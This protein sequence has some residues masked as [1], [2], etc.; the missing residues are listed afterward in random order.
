MKHVIR[1]SSAALLALALLLSAC[2]GP[3]LPV[4]PSMLAVTVAVDLGGEAVEGGDQLTPQGFPY[5]PDDGSIAGSVEVHVYDKDGDAVSFDVSGGTYTA[6]PSGAVGFITLTPGSESATV[7][8]PSSGN[9]YRFESFGRADGD[10]VAYDERSQD[11]AVVPSV[12]VTLRSVLEEAILVPRYPTAVATPGQVLDL[13]LV[14]MANGH[15]DFPTDYLQVPVGDFTATYGTVTNAAAGPSSVRGIRLTV[16]PA[17]TGDVTVDGHVTGLLFDGTAYATGDLPFHGGAGFSLSC[18]AAVGGEVAVDL[19]PPTVTLDSFD[20]ATRVVTGTASDAF[21]IASVEIY[22]GPVLMASTDPAKVSGTVSLIVFAPG[23]DEFTTTLAVDPVGGISA[24]ALDPSGN[25]ASTE[26]TFDDGF[27]YVDASA[28][29]G[30]D[31]SAAAPFDTIQEGIDAV[32]SGGTVFVRNGDYDGDHLVIDKPLTLRGESEAGVSVRLSTTGYGVEVSA[33]DVTIENLTIEGTDP[34]LSLSA[35]YGVKVSPQPVDDDPSTTDPVLTNFAMTDVTVKGFGR[36][37]VDL[38]G[39]DGA[40]LTR[41][42]ADGQGTAGV[43]IAI[44]GSRNVALLGVS[45]LGNDWG[46]VGLYSTPFGGINGVSGIHVDT[47][48]TFAEPVE[49]YSD[50]GAGPAGAAVE[51]L[52]LQGFTHVVKNPDFRADGDAFTFYMRTESGAVALANGLAT[53]ERSYV[54][55]L[56]ADVNGFVVAQNRFV[57]GVGM[58]L[59]T[60]IDAALP[61]ATIE[62]ASGTHTITTTTTVSKRVTL[63]GQ[64]GAVIETSGSGFNVLYIPAGGAGTVVEDLTFV[65]TDKAGVHNLVQIG[66]DDV[67]IRNNIFSGQWQAGDSD[68]TRALEIQGGLSGLLIDGNTVFAL[69]QPAYINGGTPGTT[70]TIS[71]NK[72]YGTKGWVVDGALMT[73]SG[74][75]WRSDGGTGPSE[76]IDCDIALLAATPNGVPQYDPIADLEAANGGDLLNLPGSCDQRVP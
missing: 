9:P 57:V 1:A 50:T 14:V 33:D 11:V 21:G 60:A 38:L 4:D 5:D 24:V 59:Q 3:Q 18:P 29:P 22:D 16:D 43:G 49:V 31:G 65:K 23:S 52:R 62:I 61:G 64:P 36:S 10:V 53:P 71:N 42:T 19:V 54:Q 45:T 20:P 35:N 66:A 41:V 27:V 2:G 7:N 25:E 46:G 63:T 13:M 26:P 44:S 12:F 34:S 47:A 32:A 48:S 37:E 76:N 39:V 6:A 74:N 28:G 70:G 58:S 55:K 15:S 69:R 40:Y 51:D 67:T 75:T 17:C 30:G 8:L 73:F 68:I 72:V 56:G